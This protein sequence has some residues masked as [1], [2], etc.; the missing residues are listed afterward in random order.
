MDVGQAEALVC[1]MG[2]PD[3]VAFE[4]KH[5][6][7][8]LG[9]ADIIVHDEYTGC[10]RA[11]VGREHWLIVVPDREPVKCAAREMALS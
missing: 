11:G 7:K 6:R 10:R 2:G 5:P 4:T 3:L 8:Q 1:R 9:D